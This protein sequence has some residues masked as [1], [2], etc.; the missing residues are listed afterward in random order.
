ME[1][2]GVI[3]YFDGKKLYAVGEE[4]LKVIPVVRTNVKIWNEIIEIPSGNKY[5]AWF[6]GNTE[7]ELALEVSYQLIKKLDNEYSKNF[8]KNN[9]FFTDNEDFLELLENNVPIYTKA[10]IDDETYMVKLTKFLP[11]YLAISPETTFL[12]EVEL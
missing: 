1:E 12:K 4:V 6:K 11:K 2:G 7:I 5:L 8:I 10:R 9:I 3:M